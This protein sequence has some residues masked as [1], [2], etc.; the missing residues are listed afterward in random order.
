[1]SRLELRAGISYVR[2]HSRCLSMW[3]RWVTLSGG[4]ERLSPRSLRRPRRP[5]R[6][7]GQAGQSGPPRTAA[8]ASIS[9]LSAPSSAQGNQSSPFGAAPTH[10]PGWGFSPKNV[11]R[12]PGTGCG[13]ASW[14][15]YLICRW[16]WEKI[17]LL[18][19]MS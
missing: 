3:A 1:M 19:W 14:G 5:W 8:R 15:P 13:E 7:Q 12:T 6:T 16:I 4:G 9:P 11:A 10:C 2:H 17:G 18:S